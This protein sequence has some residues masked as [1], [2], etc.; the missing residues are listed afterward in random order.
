MM[1]WRGQPGDRDAEM[2]RNAPPVVL[3]PGGDLNPGRRLCRPLPNH[4][5]TGPLSTANGITIAYLRRAWTCTAVARFSGCTTTSATLPLY[6]VQ[7]SENG[8]I[9]IGV[10]EDVVSRLRGLQ[11]G[12]PHELVI[13]AYV[14]ES[15]VGLETFLHSL[16]SQHL[17]RGEWFRPHDDVM[18]AVFA[19]CALYEPDVCEECERQQRY[20][21]HGRK[22]PANTVGSL[23][24]CGLPGGHI[25]S[26]PV[27][28]GSSL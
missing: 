26:A 20:V 21:D 15:P 10:A 1:I 8:A 19:V 9:K 2:S 3:R 25:R 5:A 11:V 27:P 24:T 4:S 13:L 6:F 23:H 22:V 17:I 16:L 12:N 7:D 18:D 14:S 28:A